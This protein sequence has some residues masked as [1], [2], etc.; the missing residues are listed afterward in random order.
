MAFLGLILLI[1]LSAKLPLEAQNLTQ[2]YNSDQSLERGMIVEIDKSDPSKVKASSLTNISQMHGVVVNANDAPVALSTAGNKYFV[3][4]NGQYEILVSNLGGKIAIGDYIT[5]SAISG[6]GTKAGIVEEAVIGKALE[7]FDGQANVIESS[8][9]KNSA[10]KDIK[11]QIGRIKADIA[12]GRNPLQKAKD[13][14][15]PSF[16]KK[17]AEKIAGKEVSTVKIYLSALVFFVSSAVSFVLMYGGVRSGVIS[18]GRNPLSKKSIVK[19]MLQVIVTGLIVFL[20]G[21]FGV[22]LLLRI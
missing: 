14:N 17:A 18:V 22:Y 13:P 10:G 15:L 3:A 19:S 9:V 16:L 1:T 8:Q 5:I 21:L 12:V 4:K 20:L 2:S 7:V 6:I 11:V